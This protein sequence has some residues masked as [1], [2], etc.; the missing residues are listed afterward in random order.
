MNQGCSRI[1][2]DILNIYSPNCKIEETKE[3]IKR[4]V[5]L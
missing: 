4:V 2:S 3:Q 5:D 1:P